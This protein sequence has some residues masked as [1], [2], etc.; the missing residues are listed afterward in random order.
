MSGCW[1]SGNTVLRTLSSIPHQHQRHHPIPQSLLP[2]LSVFRELKKLWWEAS[3]RLHAKQREGGRNEDMGK[4]RSWDTGEEKRKL[5]EWA[6]DQINCDFLCNLRDKSW[7]IS[8][9]N[10]SVWSVSSMNNH[11]N[12]NIT[13]TALIS[14]FLY[15]CVPGKNNYLWPN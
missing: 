9:I 6:Q 1:H 13:V 12:L 11:M 7:A 3:E 8:C 15:Q 2:C 14:F 5:N 10:D 4:N